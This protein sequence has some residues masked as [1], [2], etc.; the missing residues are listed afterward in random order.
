MENDTLI[1][2]DNFKFTEEYIQ[3]K[4]NGFFVM[5]TQKYVIENLYVFS[6]E[7]DKLIE[8][9]SGLIYE[10]EIKV[11]R[12][13]YKNDFKNKKDKHVILEGKEEHIPSYEEYKKRF[14]HYGSDISD[15]YYRTENFKK[16]NYFYYAVP[17]GMIDISEVPSYAGLIYVLPEGKHETKDGNWCSTGIYT[18]KQAPKLHSTK[19]TDDELSL[20]EKFYYNMLS[21][22]GKYAE[23]KAIRLLTE[24]KKNKIPYG[25]LYNKYE[26]AKKE[27]K[28]LKTLADTESKNAK[29]F[30][31]TM[32][33]DY[34][35]IRRYREKIREL[36]PGFDFIKFEDEVLEEYK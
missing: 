7:S 27:N 22:K 12:S 13:D 16:P 4:L 25:E 32:Q 6:W 23:E 30:S 31:E 14:A 9:R 36:I 8:T 21:W 5:N 10:Y 20:G 1:I 17:E 18:V 29:L 3:R 34:R 33:D 26:E 24:D 19:Y 15:K 2:E 28:A 11:S 35:I